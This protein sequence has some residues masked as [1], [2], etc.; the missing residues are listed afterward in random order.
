M[1]FKTKFARIVNE[2]QLIEAVVSAASIEEAEEKF[3]NK[4]FDR[5][6]IMKRD[7]R[8][9]TKIGKPEFERIA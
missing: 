1:K 5:F 6:L 7:S 9:I 3:N 4:E 8:D 2:S